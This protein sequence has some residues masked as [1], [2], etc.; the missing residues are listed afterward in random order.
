MEK[1][2][3]KLELIDEIHDELSFVEYTTSAAMLEP[4]AKPVE[5]VQEQEEETGNKYRNFSDT[6]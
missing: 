6:G 2:K 4:Q 1:R 3:S 5:E